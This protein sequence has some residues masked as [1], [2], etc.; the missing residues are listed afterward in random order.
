M[1]GIPHNQLKTAGDF[2]RLHTMALDG[3][4]RPREVATLIGY[5]RS[6]LDGRWRY[7]RDRVLA[8]GEEPDGPEPDYRVLIEEADDGTEERRQFKRVED[9]NARIHVL[10]YD[11]AT[12]E[13]KITELE[14]LA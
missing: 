14:G 9:A 2:E 12:V 5:W 7:D 1:K 6:L 13:N 10:G 3:E 11:A 8:A 4:L